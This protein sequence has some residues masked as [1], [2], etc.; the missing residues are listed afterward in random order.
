MPKSGGNNHRDYSIF[1]NMSTEALEDILRSDSQLQNDEDSDMDAI[2]YIME[3][4]AKREKENPTG[5]FTD[6]HTAWTSFSENYLP[7]V[8]DNKSLYDYEDIEEQTSIEQTPF[9]I[10]SPPR[11]NLQLMRIACVTVA[12]TALL[13]AG[14]MTASA[15]G[16]DLW[17]TVAK[18]TKDTFGF[19]TTDSNVEEST[20]EIG[21]TVNGSLQKTLD[22]YGITADLA[23]TWFPDGYMFK[24]IDVA[25]TPVRTAINAI[26]EGKDD[27]I[28]VTIVLLSKPS[29]RTYEKDGYDITVYTANEIEHYIMTNIDLTNVIWKTENYECSVSGKFSL[30]DAKK[31]IDSIYE[32]K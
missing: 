5:R 17:G 1:D 26:Y 11:R 20:L 10:S 24:N 7:Y 18:W 32:R 6:A 21:E 9:I 23:P 4:I 28:S 30:K 19:S 22:Q 3:V 8:E 27:E 25:E 2:L 13:L 12:I 29:T 31:I 14:T 15:M 16:F